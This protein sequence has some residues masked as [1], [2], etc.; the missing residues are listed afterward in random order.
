MRGRKYLVGGK[1]DTTDRVGV[2]EDVARI[3][4]IGSIGSH[5]RTRYIE[6]YPRFSEFGQP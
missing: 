4:G 6:H 5:Q 3:E 2:E 1:V